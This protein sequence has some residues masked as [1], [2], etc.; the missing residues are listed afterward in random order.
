[1]LL[2]QVPADFRCTDRPVTVQLSCRF[3]VPKSRSSKLRG[4]VCAQYKDV[5][6][7]AKEYMDSLTGLVWD[8]DRQVTM[9]YIEKRFA[10]PGE[11]NEPQVDMVITIS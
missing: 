6:N 4:Q 1:M 9:L 5:D 8:D 3:A 11:P 2:Q 10:D 7:I